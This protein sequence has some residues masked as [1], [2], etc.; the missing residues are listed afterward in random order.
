MGI[1]IGVDNIVA[2][3]T[4]NQVKKSWIVKG[5]AVKSIN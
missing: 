3:T 2:I 5:G 4:D 1:D